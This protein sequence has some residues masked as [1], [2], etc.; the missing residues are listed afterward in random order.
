M[1][2]S[3]LSDL[4]A[5]HVADLMRDAAATCCSRVA[6]SALLTRIRA[7]VQRVNAG[8]TRTCCPA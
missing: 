2:P 7:A 4:A 1:H 5:A 6:R 3:L 8:A